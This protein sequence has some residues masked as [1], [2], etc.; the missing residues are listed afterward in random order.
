MMALYE[1]WSLTMRKSTMVVVMHLLVP[2]VIGRVMATSYYTSLLENPLKAW[3]MT[4]T[5][6]G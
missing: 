2:M 6:L 3:G 1:E 5:Y 4:I